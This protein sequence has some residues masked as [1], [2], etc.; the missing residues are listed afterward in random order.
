MLEKIDEEVGRT[1]GNGDSD[2]TDAARVEEEM[3]DLL[4]SIVNLARKLGIEPEAALRVAN[5]KFQRR[6]EGMER[7]AAG[8]GEQ[9][10]EMS[11]VGSRS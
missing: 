7:S 10:R 5:D 9:L 3:G 1:A 6:F 2:T 11:L 4:F 8:R